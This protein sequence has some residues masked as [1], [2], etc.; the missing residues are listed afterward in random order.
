MGNLS[1]SSQAVGGLHPWPRSRGW[2]VGLVWASN[3][4]WVHP[5]DEQT[6]RRVAGGTAD[7]QQRTVLPAIHYILD[8]GSLRGLSAV[9][10][11]SLSSSSSKVKFLCNPGSLV[12][13]T[14]PIQHSG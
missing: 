2:G 10:L 14:A 7:P 8:R 11:P 13:T 6:L 9:F 4:T 5:G 3:V 12:L 1:E